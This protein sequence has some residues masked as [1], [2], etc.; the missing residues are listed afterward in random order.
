[1]NNID[2]GIFGVNPDETEAAG[3][4]RISKIMLK[5]FK[6]WKPEVS[7]NNFLNF[8]L[9]RSC[10]EKYD[11]VSQPLLMKYIMQDEDV[12]AAHKRVKEIVESPMYRA[13]I[14]VIDAG[15]AF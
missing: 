7:N 12:S 4:R 9:V 14:I 1:M 13:A 10:K 15:G 3:V 5:V 6:R 11:A 2:E 8:S